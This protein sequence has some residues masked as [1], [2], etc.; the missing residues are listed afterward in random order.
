[1][2]AALNPPIATLGFNSWD[3]QKFRKQKFTRMAGVAKTLEAGYMK[4]AKRFSYVQA[5]RALLAAESTLIRGDLNLS[6]DDDRITRWCKARADEVAHIVATFSCEASQVLQVLKILSVYDINYPDKQ[7]DLFGHGP[8][9]LRCSCE[10][11][12]R[13]QVRVLQAREV[14]ELARSWRLV[15]DKGQIYCSHNTVNRR[16]Q[17]KARNAKLLNQLKAT[18]QVGQEYLLSELADLQVSNPKIRRSELMVRMRGFEDLAKS[19]GRAGEFYTITCPSKYHSTNKGGI[20]NAKWNESTVREA[21]NY[22]VNLWARIRAALDRR[23]IDVYGFR[24]AEPHSDGCPHWHCL[25]FV[26]P[27]AVD[28]CRTVV[29]RYALAED[30]GEKGAADNRFKAVSIDPA[31]GSATGYI[32]KYISKNIDGHGIHDDLYG[33]DAKSSAVRIEAWAACHGIR[34]F[35]QIGGPSVTVWRE[36]RRLRDPEEGLVEQCRVAA[37]SA[38]WAA[39]CLLMGSG[40]DQALQIARL[41]E[42]DPDTGE[43]L[44]A[45]H[46]RYGEP[47]VGRIVGLIGYGQAV[48]TRVWTWTTERLAD[49]VKSIKTKPVK[50]FALMPGLVGDKPRGVRS[51]FA[52][53]ALSAFLVVGGP[54]ARSWSSVNNCTG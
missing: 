50:G 49:A 52:E 32:A 21:N 26:E 12:W 42:V 31:R 2:I 1:M 11:W 29:Q 7:A 24:V 39:F 22:L 5:N 10:R 45:V 33:H 23:G 54:P 9:L 6:W 27:A 16:R 51:A 20:P 28:E 44:T 25:L 43:C 13:R 53:A 35:Q 14:E 36:L 41:N 17:Q 46:N 37:D 8:A 30:G 3:N 40:R 47:A 34:Q 4:I 48:I 18:N 38:D 15:H 19:Q